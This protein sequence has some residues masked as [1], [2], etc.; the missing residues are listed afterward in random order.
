MIAGMAEEGVIIIEFRQVGNS[1]KVSAMDSKTLTE[2]SIVGP[3]DAGEEQLTQTVLRKL[4]YV[5]AK[6]QGPRSKG[7]G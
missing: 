5:L 6:K 1:V 4:E 3:A 2:V 7:K